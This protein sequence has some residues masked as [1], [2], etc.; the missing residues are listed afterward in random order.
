MK[1]LFLCTAHNSLS[2][3]LYLTLSRSHYVTIEYALS[4]ERIIS[5]VGLVEPDLIICPF[6]TT[7]VPR[8]I[9]EAYLTLIVHRKSSSACSLTPTLT[10]NF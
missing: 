3:R 1:I 8:Q 10:D 2:Q 5:A 9:Y 6:L 7:L 4:D